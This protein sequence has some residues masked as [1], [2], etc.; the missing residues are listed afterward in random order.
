MINLGKMPLYCCEDP[1]LIEN[2]EKAVN[3]SKMWDLHHR[4]EVSEDGCHIM[5]TPQELKDKNMYY[6]RPASELIF[7]TRK[8]HKK[9]HN[10]TDDFK[11]ICS[12]RT[13]EKNPFYGKRHNEE[14]L[15]KMSEALVGRHWNLT[16]ETK[17]KQSAWQKGK[18]HTKV[19][20]LDSHG[21][22]HI[23]DIANAKK[24][25]PDWKLIE[26]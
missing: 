3:D 26:E 20:W 21:E 11:I 13:G 9:L 23:M 6:H 19:K 14:S 15:K 24:W 4:L 25:H 12:E 18:E 17:K 2:Y 16:E 22:I 8:E 7:L 1:S 5:F 10:G